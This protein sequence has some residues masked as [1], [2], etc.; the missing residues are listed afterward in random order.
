ML[1]RKDTSLMGSVHKSKSDRVVCAVEQVVCVFIL[2]RG[3][4]G[5]VCVHAT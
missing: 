1:S 4:Y 2:Q 3:Q 5:E